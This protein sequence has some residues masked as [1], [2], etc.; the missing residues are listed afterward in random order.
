MPITPKRGSLFHAETQLVSISPRKLTWDKGA[1][2]IYETIR[3]EV[4]N[5][6]DETQANLYSRG[7]EKYVR[8]CSAFASARFSSSI[9]RSDGELAYKLITSSDRFFQQG[10][11]DA[12]AKRLMDHHELVREIER[13]LATNF[14]GEASESEIKRAFRHN[15]KHK[16]AVYNALVDMIDSGTLVEVKINNTGGRPKT[17]L[18]LSGEEP[19]E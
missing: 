19:K 11:D 12:A 4:R 9:S 14:N 18:R 15:K 7:P 13:R 8:L 3:L 2:E 16:D 6:P 5:N 10:L 1:R 17:V